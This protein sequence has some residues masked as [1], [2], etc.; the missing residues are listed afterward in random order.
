MHAKGAD[1]KGAFLRI[2]LATELF[3]LSNGARARC[4]SGSITRVSSVEAAKAARCGRFP[5]LST[6]KYAKCGGVHSIK[7]VYSDVSFFG[8]NGAKWGKS[9]DFE[10]RPSENP[11]DKNRPNADDMSSPKA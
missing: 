4:E 7:V 1:A 5:T 3:Y 9:T 8:T 6:P 11:S 10:S 2:S